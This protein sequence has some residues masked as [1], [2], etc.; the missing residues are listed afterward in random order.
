MVPSLSWFL[1]AF[2]RKEAVISSQIEGS[3]ATLIDLFTFESETETQ[4]GD[5]QEVCNYVLALEHARK[6]IK[7][8]RGLPLSMRLLNECHKILMSGV[9]GATKGPGTI[10]RTQNWIGGT[11]PGNAIFVPP[12]PHLLPDALSALEKYIHGANGLPELVRV[13]LLHAQFETIHPYLDGNGR[14]GRLFITLLL[15][16]YRLLSQPILYLSLYFKTHREEYYRLLQAV[17]RD[18]DWESWMAFF[19]DGVAIVSDTAVTQAR[20][21]FGLI[22][23]DRRNVLAAN[24]TSVMATRLFELLPEH[25][26]LT[27]ARVTELLDTTKPTAMKAVTTL[28]DA[29]V[30]K[31]TTGKRRD[32]TFSY[33]GYLSLLRDDPIP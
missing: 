17:R 26:I 22:A 19:L 24:T 2:V 14:I 31:E 28:V 18:G 16:H 15:E 3:Q 27:I 10:R 12:P 4:S 29:Q 1:Y 21:L 25:P 30:L 8:K 32:R 13:G 7:A 33:A 20:D 23:G 6:R 5:V 11:R 9:R